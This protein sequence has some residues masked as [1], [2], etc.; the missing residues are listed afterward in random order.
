VFFSTKNENFC[1]TCNL[2]NP[3]NLDIQCASLCGVELVFKKERRGKEG[4]VE[5]RIERVTEIALASFLKRRTVSLEISRVC[6]FRYLP[7]IATFN[8]AAVTTKM[9]NNNKSKFILFRI[10]LQIMLDIWIRTRD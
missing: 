2:C 7:S 1:I 3:F 9:K 10:D 4:A 5:V 8:G 6:L